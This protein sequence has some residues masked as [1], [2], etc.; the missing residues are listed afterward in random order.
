MY[1]GIIALSILAMIVAASL[2]KLL[3]G[4]V[5]RDAGRRR[6]VWPSSTRDDIASE[7]SPGPEWLVPSV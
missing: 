1:F 7:W 6:G 3:R 2:Q 4:P 5:E